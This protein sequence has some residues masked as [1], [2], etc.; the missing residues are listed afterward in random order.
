[1][2]SLLTS[3]LIYAGT[4]ALLPKYANLV[5]I[6]GVADSMSQFIRATNLLPE[7][8]ALAGMVGMGSFLTTQAVAEAKPLGYLT[9]KEAKNPRKLD[10][11]PAITREEDLE[12]ESY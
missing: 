12:T 4:K 1:V 6:G 2:F 5:L 9:F 11:Y 10:G 8:K 7:P 3:G